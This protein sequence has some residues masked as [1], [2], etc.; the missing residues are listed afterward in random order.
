MKQTITNLFINF[1]LS[2]TSHY[3]NISLILLCS[4]MLLISTHTQ[5]QQKKYANTTFSNLTKRNGLSL[6][7]GSN[8]FLGDLGGSGGNGQPFIKDW[9]LKTTKLF[10][11][12][13]YTYFLDNALSL[14]GDFHFTSVS[15]A[16]SLSNNTAGH[17][18]G[19][20]NR[21]LSFKSNIFEMQATAELYP[22][23]AILV[24]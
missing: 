2:N 18:L 17:S 16:D 24:D 20:Y 15:G 6:Q 22:L 23:Q 12:L 10:T 11:G 4:S 8:S 19:R 21:D 14:N 3:K 1:K 13:S 7:L 5:A 9:D